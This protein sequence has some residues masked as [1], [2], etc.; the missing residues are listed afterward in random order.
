MMKSLLKMSWM[1]AKLFL[2][3]PVGAFF[4]LAFPLI[5][6]FIFGTVYS[7]VPAGPG[8][9]DQEAIGTSDPGLYR[10]GHWYHWADGCHH[11]PGDLP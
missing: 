8:L 10:H 11:H 6:L 3:E 9:A 4:T 2:R 5:M 7:N 1:E